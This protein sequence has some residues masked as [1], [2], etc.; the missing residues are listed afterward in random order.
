MQYLKGSSL[1]NL[2]DL[3]KSELKEYITSIGQKAF[4][5][6]QIFS[7]VHGG[8]ES[9]DEM[10]NIPI[11]L[12]QKLSED[13]E[14]FLPTVYKKLVSKLDGTVKYLFSLSDGN[15][16]ES[17]VMDYH[18]GKSICI[19][20]Q[21]GCRMGCT[22]CASTLHGL[23]RNLSPFEIE[24]QILRAQKDL[25]E[26]ISNVVIMGIG[27]PFDNYDNIIKF[28]ENINDESGMNM[29]YRHITLSTCGLAD[30]IRD[31]ADEEI[32]INLAISLHAPT[33][34]V[35]R[36]LMPVAKAYSLEKLMSACDYYFEKTHRRITFEYALVKG[37]NASFGEAKRLA[38]L[39]RGRN[40]HVNL[41]PVNPVTERNN[42]RTN[43]KETRDF[44]KAL[45]SMGINATIRREL[46]ADIN[47]SCGQL[48]NNEL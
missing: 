42:I 9:P 29:G 3:T 36:G 15:I 2:G 34:E 19:S 37:Q 1:M 5:T 16:I 13:F 23:E 40:C 25:G 6:G 4:R 20:S 26:K 18:H 8:I 28:L 46:G 45:E 44:Q 17:V 24:G 10:T 47:A 31:F 38:E 27:E 30:R 35:R 33:D 12:R 7:W 39:L 14:I 43:E 21:V 22:F 11:P 32:P 41:I 48:R